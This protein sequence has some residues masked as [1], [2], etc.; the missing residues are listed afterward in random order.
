MGRVRARREDRDLALAAEMADFA[1]SIPDSPGVQRLIY[2]ELIPL[3]HTLQ[4]SFVGVEAAAHRGRPVAFKVMGPWINVLDETFHLHLRA[5]H[6]RELW[7]VRV[8]RR[9]PPGAAMSTMRR[10]KAG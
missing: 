4:L 6:V 7:A 3:S 8:S 5:D 10:A 2:A 9:S 1:G